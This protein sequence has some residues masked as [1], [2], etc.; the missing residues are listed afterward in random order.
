VVGRLGGLV[1]F[2]VLAS[3]TTTTRTP[4]I[5]GLG[6][7]RATVTT[8]TW[9]HW[10]HW[11]VPAAGWITGVDGVPLMT[12]KVELRPG[13]HTVVIE[14]DKNRPKSGVSAACGLSFQAQPGRHYYAASEGMGAAW[15][16]TLQD[17]KGGVPVACM[18]LRPA[19]LR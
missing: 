12:D 17:E 9:R 6:P 5:G 8:R 2:L 10:V 7:D 16:A 1:V 15:H 4:G 18:P 3:C 13:M 11:V 14:R 19:P